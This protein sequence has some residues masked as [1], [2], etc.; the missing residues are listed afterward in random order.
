VRVRV[1]YRPIAEA[2]LSEAVRT[3]GQV[4]LILDG[5][6]IGN[7]HQL[8]MVALAYRRR[9]LPL[10][11]TWVRTKRGHS[12]GHK[13]RALLA[14]LR[15]LMPVD[16][17]VIVLGDSEF[18]PLQDVLIQW[19]WFYVLRQKGSHLVRRTPDQPWQRCDLLVSQPGQRRW[20]TDV[21]LTRTPRHACHLLALWQPGHK[22][23]WLLATNLPS[24]RLTR[25]HYKRRMWIEEM[26]GD[27]KKHGFDL[28]ASRLQHFLRLSRLTLAVAMLYVSLIAFGSQTIKNG[29][30]HLV[31]R[32]D[33]RDLSLFRIGFDMLQR[34]LVNDLAF[35]FRLI[36][37]F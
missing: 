34:C 30:R 21:Q 37:Y 18:T 14:Y 29:L 24:P 3:S 8:L 15:R 6:K 25:M 36:P 19:N 1:W 9:T 7:G 5:T 28:E 22:E 26:F 23:P 2:L 33:R 4:R 17:E 12:S 27:F 13:Q 35:S 32:R 16:A 20:L 11:W 10:V 31:D